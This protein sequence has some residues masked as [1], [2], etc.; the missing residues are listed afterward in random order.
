MSE[1][2]RAAWL[3]PCPGRASGWRRLEAAA[4]LPLAEREA[5]RLGAVRPSDL[6]GLDTTGVPVWQVVRPQAFDLP[7][8]VTVL[9]GKGWTHEQALLGAW[10]EFLE[11]HWA[12]RAEVPVEVCR[13]SELERAGRLFLPAAA[14]PL[15]LGTADPGDQPLAWV[16]ATTF[17]GLEVMVPA[18][19]VLCPFVPPVGATNPPIWRS[20]G[21]ASG[22][23]VT[24][25]VFHGLLELIERDAVAVAEL[26][27][28]GTS[29]DLATSGS[30]W[31]AAL[32][33][34]LRGAG[35]DL[36]VKQ[37]PALG[38]TSAFLASLDDS[39]SGNPM[40]LVSGHAAHIDP[41]LALEGAVL[42][43][44]QARVAIIAGS[45]EDLDSYAEF[46]TMSFSTVRHEL[47]W[48]LDP[49]G[50]R[51][52]APAAP[53]PPPDD[54][55]ETVLALEKGLREHSFQPLLVVEMTP[56]SYPVPV[57][58]VIVPTLSEITHSSYRLGRRIHLAATGAEDVTAAST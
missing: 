44:L 35:L 46:A 49:T 23:H 53:Q 14:M 7:G 6:S 9:N 50:E 42:E 30:P 37:I 2:G 12:E 21:L 34:A 18:H 55:A 48:W 36:E 4:A 57:V 3:S 16:A 47:S 19:D 24:E 13:G 39:R 32:L 54:L 31:I 52:A 5:R 33:P 43:A 20:A 8:N 10:M 45:R 11:R 56:P 38:G 15:P 41:Y 29:V 22:T 58:R 28:V 1:A 40:R 17:W 25:A 26:G 27:R 51:V